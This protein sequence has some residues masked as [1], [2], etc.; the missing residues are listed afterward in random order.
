[1]KLI[2]MSNRVSDWERM[3]SG[4]LYNSAS[5]DIESNTNAE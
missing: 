1:M 5:K 3:V 4:K 2:K